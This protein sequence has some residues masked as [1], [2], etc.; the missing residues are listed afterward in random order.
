M[1]NRTLLFGEGMFE[2]FRVYEGRRLA[3]AEDHLDRMAAGC[4]FFAILFSRGKA[5][6]ALKLALEEIPPDTE[7]RLRLTLIS[8]GDHCVEKTAFQTAWEPLPEMKDR[9]ASGVRLTMAPFAKFSGSPLVRFKTTACLE[10]IFVFNQAHSQ[11]F[12]DAL[13]VNER[14]EITEGSITNVFFLSKGH[15]LTPPTDAGLLPGV[16]RK[17]IMEIADVLGLPLTESTVTPADLNR[18]DGAFVTNS[19]IEILPASCVDDT[20]YAIPEMITALQEGYQRRLES[21]LFSFGP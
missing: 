2:T 20:H 18:F 8:H 15:I 1:K 11:G 16:T 10:N 13:F 9:Q 7:A 14:G 6:K 17:Q 21:S 5:I 4:R 3:F 19:V 12:F